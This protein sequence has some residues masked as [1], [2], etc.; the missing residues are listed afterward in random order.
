MINPNR[1]EV[2][3]VRGATAAI[4]MTNLGIFCIKNSI[5]TVVTDPSFCEIVLMD[6][7]RLGA[8]LR[9]K[10]ICTVDFEDDKHFAIQKFRN[11]P[12]GALGADGF[13]I[14]L[15]PARAD[16]EAYNELKALTDFIKQNLDP[17]KEIR[18]CF[19]FRSRPYEELE[20]FMQYLPQFPATYLRTDHNMI[21]SGI[22]LVTHQKDIEFL[23]TYVGSP[24]KVSDGAI[25]MENLD[26]LSMKVERFDVT[27]G[28][29]KR[30][31]QKIADQEQLEQAAQGR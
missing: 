21:T 6:R 28:Q 14:L 22:P 30:L 26:A 19:G 3:L 25:S 11:I 23:R 17:T 27:L 5:P 29:A 31:V 2:N 18:W 20:A 9:Y 4:D 10:V 15:S 7:L 12:K 24:I 1:F 16:K 8:T 13:E